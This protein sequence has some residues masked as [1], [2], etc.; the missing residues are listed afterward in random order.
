MRYIL[1]MVL[2]R[3]KIYPEIWYQIVPIFSKTVKI[4]EYSK[5]MK[6]YA[7]N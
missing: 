7:N 3:Y 6:I 5:Q 2:Q 1:I 4:R